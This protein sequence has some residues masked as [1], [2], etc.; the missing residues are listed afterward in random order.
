MKEKIELRNQ[1]DNLIYSVEKTMKE[2][3]DKV[4]EDEK[5]KITEEIKDLRKALEEDDV[6]N[7]KSGIEK[8]TASSHKLAEE[9][10]KKASAQTQQQEANKESYKGSQSEKK[11]EKEEEK[12]VDADYEVEK[13]Q[14]KE[15]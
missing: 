11:E 3:E 8:L 10:Y 1:A 6:D 7:M 14:D 5:N 4:S 15:D 9:I 12:V 2:S 13:D